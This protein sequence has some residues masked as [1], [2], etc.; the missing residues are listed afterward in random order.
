[1]EAPP[2]A[3]TE[4][5]P[6]ASAETPAP[7]TASLPKKSP[8]EWFDEYLTEEKTSELSRKRN[9][10]EAAKQA[11]RDMAADPRVNAFTN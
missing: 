1:V 8:Q 4:P 6:A 11:I 5:S 10:G 7:E 2:I 9:L 3:T